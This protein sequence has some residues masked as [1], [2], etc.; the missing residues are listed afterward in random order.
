MITASIGKQVEY[1]DEKPSLSV[2]MNTDYSKEIQITMKEGVEMKEHAA[3]HPIVV[4]VVSGKISFGIEDQKIEM[5]AGMMIAV[6]PSVP[7]SLVADLDS[8]IR[9][10][11]LKM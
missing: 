10:S 1:Q 4:H 2:L 3:R 6:E 11:I 5:E 9:L 7:H 8:I